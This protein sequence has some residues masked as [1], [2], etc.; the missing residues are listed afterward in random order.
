MTPVTGSE[1]AGRTLTQVP[2]RRS[3]S[4]TVS[5]TLPLARTLFAPQTELTS[6]QK[7]CE[8]CPAKTRTVFP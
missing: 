6:Q 7:T 2:R 8:V 1:C 4:R 5:S 3:H